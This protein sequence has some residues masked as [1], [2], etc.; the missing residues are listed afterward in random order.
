M[1]TYL[2]FLSGGRAHGSERTVRSV[3]FTDIVDSTRSAAAIGDEAWKRRLTYVD[4]FVAL[5][6]ARFG[7]QLIKQT[8]DGHLAAF[9]GPT[10]A[11]RAASAILRSGPTLE[12]EIRA[13]V[14]TGEIELRPGG[15]I[16]GIAVH[17]AA[18]V[19]ALAGPRQLLVSRTVADLVAGG[20]FRLTPIGDHLLK[21]VDGAWALYEVEIN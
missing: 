11:I 19:A 20:G 21:G 2:D 6:L 14:H 10:D 1:Q 7:G 15:D 5:Q 8:G 9:A 4:E 12:V 3:L 13:G 17:V 18:R 16:A